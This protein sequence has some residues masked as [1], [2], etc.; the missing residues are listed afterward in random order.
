MGFIFLTVPFLCLLSFTLTVCEPIA[1]PNLLDGLIRDITF[2]SYRDHARRFRTGKVIEIDLPANLSGV[3]VDSVRFRCGSLRRYGGEIKEFRIGIGVLIR[4]CNTTRAML[5]RQKLGS[6]WASVYQSRLS[7][8]RLI[9]PV[10]GLLAYDVREVAPAELGIE[11]GEE[12]PI[13]V[14]FKTLNDS[15]NGLIP[16]CARF[17]EDG[18]IRI[19]RQSG[20]GLC[21]TTRQ[22]HFGLVVEAPLIPGT[23]K[24][25]G[26]AAIG[27][28]CIGAMLGFFLLC[29][30]AIA[31]LVNGK[32]R[33]NKARKEEMERRAYEEEALKVVSMAD[34]VSS[35]ISTNSP[36]IHVQAC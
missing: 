30:L 7:G 24:P 14:D 22:G 10:I 33:K 21:T 20:P 3:E 27:G 9:S 35:S 13:G 15:S 4:P 34:H 1:E 28:G 11:A 36:I 8:Y 5:I 6:N 2:R 12:S 32:K 31:M 29:L 18:E 26:K 17:E 19:S 16:L 23:E 25:V